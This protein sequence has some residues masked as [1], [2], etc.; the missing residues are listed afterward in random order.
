ML[1]FVYSAYDRNYRT[2]IGKS[3]PFLTSH[4]TDG[5][6]ILWPIYPHISRKL[7]WLLTAELKRPVHQATKL[8]TRLLTRQK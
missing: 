1:S 6:P 3:L 2:E 5:L 4:Y 7:G 8:T